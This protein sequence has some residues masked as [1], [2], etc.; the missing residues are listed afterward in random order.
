MTK[1]DRG[2]TIVDRTYERNLHSHYAA[3]GPAQVSEQTIAAELA[4]Q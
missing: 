2:S 3:G 4:D 1:P